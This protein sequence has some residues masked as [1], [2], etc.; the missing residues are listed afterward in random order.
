M[1]VLNVVTWIVQVF[2]GLFFFGG[3]IPK[4]SG[5]GLERWTGFADLPRSLTLLIGISEILGGLALVL[6]M[7]IGT[8]AWLTALAA[9][10]LAVIMFMA[11]GFHIRAGEY[12][13][14]LETTLWAAIAALVAI[15]RWHLVSGRMTATPHLIVALM[16][17]LVPA[18]IINLVVLLSRPPGVRDRS[19]ARRDASDAVSDRVSTAGE[20]G[21][22]VAHVPLNR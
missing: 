13:A 15:A 7:A 3:A 9:I 16:A 4:L 22:R 18:V 17:V 12:L 11:T 8:A 2:L 6:P 14:A 1:H 5:R 21:A 20:D 10:G 19:V